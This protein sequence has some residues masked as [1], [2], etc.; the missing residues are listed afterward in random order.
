VYLGAALGTLFAVIISNIKLER[1]EG[2]KHLQE[3]TGMGRV[4]YWTA[5]FIIDYTKVM[6]FMIVVAIVFSYQDPSLADSTYT[7]ILIPFAL[8]PFTYVSSYFFSSDSAAQTGTIFLNFFVLSILSNGVGFLRIYPG[9]ENL[10]DLLQHLFKVIPAYVIASTVYCDS[11]CD[12]I[13]LERKKSRI[14]EGDLVPDDKWY[15]MHL[16][17]DILITLLHAVFWTIVL[18]MIEKGLFEKCKRKPDLTIPPMQLDSDVQ[19]EQDRI[20]NRIRPDV[21]VDKSTIS[22]DRP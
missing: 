12:L 22:E 15:F 16:P 3:I 18:V 20:K 11:T 6:V 17:L 19:Q 9:T 8:I 4:A 14:S 13:A 1:S 2:L 7:V 5:N 21:T 10:G